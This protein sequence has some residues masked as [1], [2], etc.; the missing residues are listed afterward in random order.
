MGFEQ[1]AVVKISPLVAFPEQKVHTLQRAH[2]RCQ[3]KSTHLC[4]QLILLLNAHMTH[5]IQ[6]IPNK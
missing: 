1:E 2:A 5:D 6:K 3:V 4:M